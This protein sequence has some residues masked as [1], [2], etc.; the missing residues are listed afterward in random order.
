MSNFE[1]ALW[2]SADEWV[3]SFPADLPKYK[4]SKKHKKIIK[5]II[6]KK[7]DKTKIKFSKG[8]VKVLLIAAALLA[9]ATTAFAVP[10]SRSYI[11]KKFS[12]HSQYS[13]VDTSKEKNV[14]SL[15]L[16]YI[17]AG[18]KC[19]ENYYS[20]NFYIEIYK[21]NDKSFVVQK[22]VL[23]G[24]IGYNTE[25]AESENIQ[26]NGIDAVYYSSDDNNEK[27][28]IFNNGDYLYIISGNID[29]KEIV[30]I[31]QNID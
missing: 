24:D 1:E 21:N 19:T 18:F 4:F 14:K 10:T 9:V 28:I 13:V 15:K 31:A 7:K 22:N 12:D 26:I 29:K 11:I 17:P 5:A 27:G 23:S 8:A 2:L 16:N 20:D 3:N 6:Y 30:Q 25:H